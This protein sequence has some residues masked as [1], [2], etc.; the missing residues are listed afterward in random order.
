LASATDFRVFAALVCVSVAAS[1]WTWRIW[2]APS[3][4]V[5][6]RRN[7]ISSCCF[8]AWSRKS[9]AL[10]VIRPP[11][12]CFI[13]ATHDAGIAAAGREHEGYLRIGV[14]AHLADRGA[15][16]GDLAACP[17]RLLHALAR[18]GKGGRDG[19]PGVVHRLAVEQRLVLRPAD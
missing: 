6:M 13:S 12:G 15:R 8:Q 17:G 3:T 19:R 10:G 9:S 4:M 11:L 16:E 5:S 14:Q 7:P 1:S 2:I 18:A